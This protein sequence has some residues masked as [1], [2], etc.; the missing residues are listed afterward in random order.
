MIVVFLGPPGA[1]KGTQCKQLV[2]RYSLVHLS[3]GDILRRE[4][5]EGTELGQKAQAYMDRGGLVPDDLIVAMMMTEM[6]RARSKGFVLDGFPR[7]LGQARELDKALKKTGRQVDVVLDLMVDDGRLELRVTGRRSCGQCGAAYHTS[8]NPPARA[9]RCDKCGGD[10]VQRPDDTPDVVRNRIQTYHDQT[11]PLVAY[12]EQNGTVRHID[13][14][15]DIDQ[16]TAA[17][18]RVMDGVGR[19]A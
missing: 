8:F 7:T 14:N 10:L 19:V 3:S 5:K 2:D 6:G 4:R 9:G 13:G 15:V 11:A 12:Y 18:F 17:L 1:G 16:V